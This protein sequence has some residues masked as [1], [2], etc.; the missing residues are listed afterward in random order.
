[1]SASPK[2]SKYDIRAEID[3]NTT[4][5][6]LFLTFMCCACIGM[7]I[8]GILAIKRAKD[9]RTNNMNKTKTE[10]AKTE[11]GF[12]MVGGS[13]LVAGPGVILL[14]ILFQVPTLVMLHANKDELINC[15]NMKFT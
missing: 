15:Y 7:I 14:Y 12:A 6:V 2:S 10:I 13:L 11:K 1:M 5:L 4:Y 8:G 3:K 9:I